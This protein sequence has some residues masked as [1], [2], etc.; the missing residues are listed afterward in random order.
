[1]KQAENIRI[2]KKKSKKK[3][4]VVECQ[5]N[6]IL[7]ETSKETFDRVHGVGQETNGLRENRQPINEVLA[8]GYAICGNKDGF[9][10]VFRQCPKHI[11]DHT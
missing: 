10:K 4:L 8:L 6:V 3:Y 11:T 9:D 1:M 5:L 2:L 7:S